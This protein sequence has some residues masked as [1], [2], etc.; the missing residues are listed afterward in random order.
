LLGERI[1]KTLP[2]FKK[3]DILEMNHIKN[4]TIIMRMYCVTF[5]LKEKYQLQNAEED[6]VKIEQNG[7]KKVKID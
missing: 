3:E 5:R 1:G 6:D 4:V 2:G 7:H